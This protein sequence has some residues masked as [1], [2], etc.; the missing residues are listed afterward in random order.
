MS[1]KIGITSIAFFAAWMTREASSGI[2]FNFSGF[3]SW[4]TLNFASRITSLNLFTDSS[5]RTGFE[6]LSTWRR[7]K[8]NSEIR[9]SDPM[10]REFLD[11]IRM[12]SDTCTELTMSWKLWT[13]PNSPDRPVSP[14]QQKSCYRFGSLW[15]SFIG[16]FFKCSAA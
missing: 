12:T 16:L 15:L 5:H 9:G 1:H 7:L 8:K 14:G 2:E 13:A 11:N 10:A 6:I 4:G 3:N